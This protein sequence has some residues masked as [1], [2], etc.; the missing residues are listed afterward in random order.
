[1][2][3]KGRLHKVI[4][5]DIA[6][7]VLIIGA[8]LLGW[9]PGPGGIPLLLGGLGLLA[10][11]HYWAHKLL[12]QLKENGLKIMDAV[13]VEKKW[14]MMTYDVMT[15]LLVMLAGVI[16]Y[17][18]DNYLWRGFAIICFALALGVFFGNRKRFQKIT[19]KIRN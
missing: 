18:Y 10:I 4:A 19:D 5:I 6:G 11:N 15:I 14:V 2:D 12:L 3:K 7:G 8:V 9:L 17:V 1:M 13:F 16:F